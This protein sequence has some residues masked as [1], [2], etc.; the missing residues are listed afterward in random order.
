[1][2]GSKGGGGRGSGGAGSGGRNYSGG[3]GGGGGIMKAPGGGG[4]YISRTTFESNPKGYFQG[5]RHG[6]VKG[7]RP[8]CGAVRHRYSQAFGEAVPLHPIVTPNAESAHGPPSQLCL[9]A[10]CPFF[11]LP[12]LKQI[13]PGFS[14]SQATNISS[15]LI[16]S[17]GPPPPLTQSGFSSSQQ[18]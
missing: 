13:R 15:F 9:P 11:V 3:K 5:L 1:M 10:P 17:E 16:F 4:G 8:A 12:H 14:S 2:G 7:R 6:F 18:R